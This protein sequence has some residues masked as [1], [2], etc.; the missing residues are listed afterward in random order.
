MLFRDDP[1]VQRGVGRDDAICRSI[2]CSDVFFQRSF[3]ELK[4]SAGRAVVMR[5][6]RIL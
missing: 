6:L 2:A 5:V 3:Y 4:M 1:T